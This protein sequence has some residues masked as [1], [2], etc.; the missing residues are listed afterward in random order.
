MKKGLYENMKKI[1]L[2][3]LDKIAKSFEVAIAL[4][5]LV[6]IAIKIIEVV[7]ELT[8]FDIIIISMDFERILSMAFALVIGVEF[9]KMLFKLTPETVIDV[10]L[11]AIARQTVIYHER[12]LD[13]LIGVIAIAGLF[14]AKKYLVNRLESKQKPEGD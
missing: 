14:A 9:T 7:L 4:L 3:H 2:K 8:G 10:L 1:G 5:L 12:T 6:V 13:L 11:F